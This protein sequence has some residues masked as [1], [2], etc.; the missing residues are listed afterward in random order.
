MKV[1]ISTLIVLFSINSMA[2]IAGPIMPSGLGDMNKL[3]DNAVKAVAKHAQEKECMGAVTVT[4][5]GDEFLVTD[6]ATGS[7]IVADTWVNIFKGKW[8]VK[9]LE[10][11]GLCH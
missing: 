9:T 4:D 5:I 8:V 7:Q 11:E 1:L 6:L 2:M 10:G 3:Y